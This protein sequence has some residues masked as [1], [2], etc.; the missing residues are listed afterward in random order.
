MTKRAFTKTQNPPAPHRACK[1]SIPTMSAEYLT[2]N[3][4]GDTDAS[5]AD[6]LN[7]PL[8]IDAPDGLARIR[9]AGVDL[10]WR[11][12]MPFSG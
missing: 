5:V 8:E 2:G 7:L 4:R 3:R 11:R 10:L 9:K 12:W 6:P 1:P